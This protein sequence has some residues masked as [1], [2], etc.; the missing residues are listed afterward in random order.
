[1]NLSIP[2]RRKG[3]FAY[4]G[5]LM[6]TSLGNRQAFSNHRRPRS[7]VSFRRLGKGR[8]IS[9]EGRLLTRPYMARE[10]LVGYEAVSRSRPA[11]LQA[12]IRQV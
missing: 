9:L 4:K 12:P 11:A 10:R 6:Q 7:P 2:C 1:M 3:L 8:Q 5:H